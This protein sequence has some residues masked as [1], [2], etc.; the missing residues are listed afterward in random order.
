MLFFKKPPL[1]QA[2]FSLLELIV[3]IVVIGILVAIAIPRLGSNQSFESRAAAAELADRLTFAQQ[4]AMNNTSKTTTASISGTSL[5]IQQDGTSL[6]GYPFD[7]SSEYNVSFSNVNLTYNSLGE[8]TSA[9]VTVTP[10]AGVD[11]C[12]EDSG[13]AWLC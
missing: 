10:S 8:T 2:A 9:T 5:D 13:Y 3:V 12:I 4:L 11:V 1:K 6:S 7:F